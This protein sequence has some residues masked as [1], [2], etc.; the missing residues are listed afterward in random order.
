MGVNDFNFGCCLMSEVFIANV[1]IMVVAL[2][3]VGALIFDLWQHRIPNWLTYGSAVLGFVLQIV[4]HGFEGLIVALGGFFVGLC[5]LM[6]FFLK[7]GMG[8]GDVKL[9][10]ALGVFVGAKSVL[11]MAACTLIA[12][13]VIGILFLAWH[14]GLGDYLSRYWIT[15]KHLIYSGKLLYVP[16]QQREAAS[17]RF[18]YATAISLGVLTV[19]VWNPLGIN[20]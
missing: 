7:G 10:A 9:M 5:V 11:L 4:M 12:G 13:G 19:F 16:P 3:L 15:I 2:L 14:R 17:K 18:P 6:P 1:P 20:I 8:A